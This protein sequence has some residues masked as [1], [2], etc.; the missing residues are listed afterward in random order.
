MG[1]VFIF[2]F[3]CFIIL[4]PNNMPQFSNKPSSLFKHILNG[5]ILLYMWLLVLK[6]T[7]LQDYRN[8]SC[9]RV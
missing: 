5:K 4:S 2:L 3:V 6:T 1:S 7:A 9:V 8:R